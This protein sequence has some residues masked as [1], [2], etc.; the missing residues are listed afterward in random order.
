MITMQT[1]REARSIASVL[2]AEGGCGLGK[3]NRGVAYS[4]LTA[5]FKF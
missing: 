5:Q 1:A 3:A 2:L 4:T